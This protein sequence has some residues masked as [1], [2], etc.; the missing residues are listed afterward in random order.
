M[1]AFAGVTWLEEPTSSQDLAGLAA[2]LRQLTPDVAAGEYSWQ[3]ADSARLI[4]AANV[5]VEREPGFS[6]AA[7]AGTTRGTPGVMQRW[8]WRRRWPRLDATSSR[9]S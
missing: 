7:A 3:L 1:A 2:V 5:A 9:S 6:T 8:S 4:E